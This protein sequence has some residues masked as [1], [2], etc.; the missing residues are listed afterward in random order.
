[1]R[2]IALP[3][4]LKPEH[5]EAQAAA[6]AAAEQAAIEAL[7]GVYTGEAIP[8]TPLPP[9]P[10]APKPAEVVYII[11]NR[12]QRPPTANTA[13]KN[14]I[15]KDEESSSSYGGVPQIKIISDEVLEER[16]Q[17]LLSLIELG[18]LGWRF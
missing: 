1:M 2:R 9:K 5:L 18:Y 15:D 10:P 6:A 16:L 4:E 3:A 14:E 11:D 17:N 13:P 7:G 8:M 12:P